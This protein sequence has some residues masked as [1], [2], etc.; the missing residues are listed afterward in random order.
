[1]EFEKEKWIES[2]QKA[3][4]QTAMVQY[5][6]AKA[7]WDQREAKRKEIKEKEVEKHKK[8]VAAWEKAKVK[9][10][11]A[12]KKQ[13]LSRP[14]PFRVTKPKMPALAKGNRRPMVKDFMEGPGSL[15][16]SS[17]S[18]SSSEGGEGG[19]NDNEEDE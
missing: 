9:A 10:A 19:E 15:L 2:Q 6:A 16:L 17:E 12:A 7:L 3:D 14:P 11:T 5:R 18:G 1:V 4:R 8:A 13:G